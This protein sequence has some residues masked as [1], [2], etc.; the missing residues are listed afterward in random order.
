[1]T[2][3]RAVVLARGLG[4]RMRAPDPRADLTA[5]QARAADEGHKALMPVNGRPFLDYVLS[6]LADAGLRQVALIV[7]PE[8]QALLDRYTS[9]ALPSRLT[10]RF[11]VQ[12]EARG[13]A[14]AV[15]AAE[16]W[17]A[18]EPFLTL[19]SD[20]LYPREALQ[21][22]AR[23]EEPGVAA[24]M[25]DDLIRRGN[26]APERINAFAIIH[27]DPE[28]FLSSI[29]EKPGA[30]T[31]AAAPAWKKDDLISMNCWRFDERIFQACRDVAPSQRGELE[32]PEAVGLAVRRGVR[33]RVLRE[34]GG[35]LDLSKRADAAEVGRRLGGLAVRL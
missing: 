24:F 21:D 2:T 6:G 23:L 35:V 13:T 11:V 9:D 12:A 14:D 17:A 8:H 29:V 18:G 5:E 3:S 30:E 27:A 32:L 34:G 10:L 16:E 7:A 31:Q 20:N 28:G 26:I 33:F 1:M 25:P 4:S 15:L 22:L 19:N